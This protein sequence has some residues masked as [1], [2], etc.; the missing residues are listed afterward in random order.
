MSRRGYVFK[1][2]QKQLI[3]PRR[4][5]NEYNWNVYTQTA[6]KIETVFT[7]NS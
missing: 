6:Y 4:N 2:E 5:S 7:S 1:D 3:L